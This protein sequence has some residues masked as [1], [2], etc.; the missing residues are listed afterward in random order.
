LIFSSLA[1]AFVIA[2]IIAGRLSIH[3]RRRVLLT[4][5]G[6]ALLGDI[7]AAGAALTVTPLEARDLIL[8]LTVLGTGEGLLMT[9]LLNAVLSGIHEAHAGSASGM[10]GTM[11]QVGGAVGVAVVGIIFFGTLDHAR[12]AGVA[13]AAAYTQAFAMA[14]IYC[15]VATA[16]TLMLLFSLQHDPTSAAPTVK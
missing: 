15:T 14:A 8:A 7:L 6:I 12:T 10:L 9:P 11:Q 4:G 2:S 1:I 3:H 5:A 16:I 13:D